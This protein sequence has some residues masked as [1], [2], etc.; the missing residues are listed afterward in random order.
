MGPYRRAREAS[1][2]RKVVRMCDNHVVCQMDLC[3]TRDASGGDSGECRAATGG[4]GPQP[5]ADRALTE[6]SQALIAL[7]DT[8]TSHRPP[9]H[10]IADLP[11]ST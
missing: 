9:F 11:R 7:L 3:V 8:G 1:G 4:G 10:Q 5:A 2:T 6:H